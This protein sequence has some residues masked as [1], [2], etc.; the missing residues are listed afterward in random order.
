ME[1]QPI[2]RFDLR[3]IPEFQRFQAANPQNPRIDARQTA[4]MYGR[5]IHWISILDLLWPDMEKLDHF[6]IEVAYIVINDSDNSVLPHSFYEYVARM[7]AMFW[8][9]QLKQRYP[10]G[11]WK[12]EIDDDS[13]MTV[14]Y[15]INSRQ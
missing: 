12:V 8:E 13:E 5:A 15:K 2:E 4:L 11:D 3:D 1:E 6:S 14:Y 7:I 10:N 9:L